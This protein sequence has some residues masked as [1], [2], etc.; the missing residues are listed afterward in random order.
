MM[1]W[2]LAL[3]VAG[4]VGCSKPSMPATSAAQQVGI[5][6]T[7]WTADGE[8]VKLIIE[9]PAGVQYGEYGVHA[10][11]YPTEWCS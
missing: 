6:G 8:C 2:L 10:M 9:R 3:L 4:L 5:Q 1:R 7:F 11:H